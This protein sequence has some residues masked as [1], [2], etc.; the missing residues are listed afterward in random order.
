MASIWD[1]LEEAGH[2]FTLVAG[3]TAGQNVYYCEHCASLMIVGGVSEI[4]IFHSPWHLRATVDCCPGI[5]APDLLRLKK[6]LEILHE[7]D[8][9]RL[10]ERDP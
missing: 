2:D 7:E 3:P 5:A 9:E 4:R 1:R 6:R 10:R 8:L